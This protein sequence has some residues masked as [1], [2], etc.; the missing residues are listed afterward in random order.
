[1]TNEN[2]LPA[3]FRDMQ[4]NETTLE[5]AGLGLDVEFTAK[6]EEYEMC[7]DR[8]M[9]ARIVGVMSDDHECVKVL[10]DYAPWD[11]YNRP[12]ENHNYYDK[13]GDPRLT[14][15]EANMYHPTEWCYFEAKDDPTKYFTVVDKKLQD[16]RY[17]VIYQDAENGVM[18]TSQLETLD[19]DETLSHI[20][21]V[22]IMVFAGW[23]TRVR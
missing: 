19:L 23:P 17:T 12:H 16:N 5:I 11:L 21:H 22:I 1:M 14:A 7:A 2:T 15:R 20:H 18:R 8:K 6:I 10:F 3:T 13:H 4:P 9:R